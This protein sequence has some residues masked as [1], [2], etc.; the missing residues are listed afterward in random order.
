MVILQMSQFQELKQTKRTIITNVKTTTIELMWDRKTK[1]WTIKVT[2]YTNWLNEWFD[3]FLLENL[4]RL[5]E[6][7]KIE[8][9]SNFLREHKQS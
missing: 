9:F 5:T 1:W 6:K 8:L 3:D 2:A 4:A 7:D